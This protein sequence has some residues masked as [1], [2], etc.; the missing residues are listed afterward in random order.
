MLINNVEVDVK[1]KF[2]ENQTTQLKIA[3]A[4]GRPASYV[5]RL[6]KKPG[7]IVNKTF[8]QMMEALGYDVE[9][10]YIKREEKTKWSLCRKVK[11]SRDHNG[12]QHVRSI[13]SRARNALV[14]QSTK[15][16]TDTAVRTVS[17]LF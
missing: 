7:G 13:A 1:T 2:I 16:N 6:I 4:V 15:Y 5:N 9:L 8:I 3:E 17:E 11:N 10:R 12:L 14:G